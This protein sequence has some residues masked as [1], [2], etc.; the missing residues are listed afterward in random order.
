MDDVLVKSLCVEDH[1][2]HLAE[3]FNVLHVYG[4]K[5]NPNKCAFRVFSGKF[6]KF[7]VNQW[8]LEANPDKI[9]DVLEMEASR[10]V[11]E[12]R[13]LT[14]RI[15]TLNHFM[16]KGINKCLPF[17]KNLRKVSRFEWTLEC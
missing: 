8:G 11:K 12:V 4:M 17:F 1:L 16:L 13:Q 3:M 14:E 10:M 9:R 15:V 7:M 2:T 5:L 6:L